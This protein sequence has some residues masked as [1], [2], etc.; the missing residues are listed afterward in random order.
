M[1]QPAD[2]L[3]V[4]SRGVE[5]FG[6]GNRRK[7]RLDVVPHSGGDGA[8]EVFAVRKTLHQGDTFAFLGREGIG[9]EDAKVFAQ[10]LVGHHPVGLQTRLGRVVDFEQDRFASH[11][12]VANGVNRSIA[13]AADN[14]VRK[15]H[16][17]V[18]VV[19][20]RPDNGRTHKSARFLEFFV[21]SIGVFLVTIA[22][23]EHGDTAD[24]AAKIAQRRSAV[25]EF[26]IFPPGVALGIM[27]KFKRHESPLSRV[28]R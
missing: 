26:F 27:D 5:R 28:G 6:L 17:G 4:K 12:R 14:Q 10:F 19:D 11:D 1:S 3:D 21:K 18:N 23:Q 7:G 16:A 15:A 8:F 24:G 22:A 20:R 2:H 9:V 13:V 25:A